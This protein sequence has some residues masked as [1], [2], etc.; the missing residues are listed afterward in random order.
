M[1]PH[2][3]THKGKQSSKDEICPEY[4]SNKRPRLGMFLD[5]FPRARL[6]MFPFKS[7]AYFDDRGMGRFGLL[8][9][10]S[11]P[12]RVFLKG[13]GETHI[14][15]KVQF[16]FSSSCPFGDSSCCLASSSNITH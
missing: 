14:F 3:H 1:R 9:S 6:I 12:E 8:G 11:E 7:P 15:H 4:T 13:G 16:H 5:E 2:T 10:S